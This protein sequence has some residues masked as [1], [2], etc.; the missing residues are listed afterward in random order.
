MKDPVNPARAPEPASWRRADRKSSALLLV[1]LENFT[2]R[3]TKGFEHERLCHDE[4]N[5]GWQGGRRKGREHHDGSG[6]LE[7]F[8]SNGKLV[9]LHAGHREIGKH[10]IKSCRIVFG[11][12]FFSA[13]RRFDLM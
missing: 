2:E 3:I 6:R 9:A 4:V 8:D 5:R 7:F 10:E 12:R 1:A 11:K 13:T